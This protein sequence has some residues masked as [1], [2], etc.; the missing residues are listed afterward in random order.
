MDDLGE[1]VPGARV[2][3]QTSA[4]A[5][6]TTYADLFGEF[7]FNDL[8]ASEIKLAVDP[9]SGHWLRKDW[10]EFVVSGPDEIYE[11]VIQRAREIVVQVVDVSGQKLGGKAVAMSIPGD[12]NSLVMGE[13]L[14][15]G[16]Y[17]FTVPLQGEIQV[18][19]RHLGVQFDKRF[20]VNAEEFTMR[21][22]EGVA[23]AVDWSALE[24]PGHT[25]LYLMAE[26]QSSSRGGRATIE[27]IAREGPKRINSEALATSRSEVHLPPGTYRFWLTARALDGSVFHLLQ[28]VPSMEEVTIAPGTPQTLRFVPVD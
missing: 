24:L 2:Y 6:L 4:G 16:A 7:R 20:D 9:K 1:R 28:D 18:M 17:R 27:L 21:L 25:W 14:S 22:P 3:G 12:T 5:Q 13:A 11:L 26:E 8:T 23:V 10:A 19:V 15:T